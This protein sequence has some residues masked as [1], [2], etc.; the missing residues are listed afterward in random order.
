MWKVLVKQGDTVDR[1]QLLCIIEAMKMEN[2]ITAHKAGTIAELPISEGAPIQAGA[3]IATIVS[4]PSDPCPGSYP[5]VVGMTR[6]PELKAGGCGD[7]ELASMSYAVKTRYNISSLRRE[8][9]K[10]SSRRASARSALSTEP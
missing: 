5:T 3:P 2:E 4:P 8:R 10:A 7:I 6:S 1:G 9:I